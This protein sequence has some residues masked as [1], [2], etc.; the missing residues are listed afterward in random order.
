MLLQ[1]LVKVGGCVC[2]SFYH[3]VSDMIKVLTETM[4]AK[5]KKDTTVI[6]SGAHLFMDY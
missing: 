3:K 5:L 6:K 2:V 1:I 4:E